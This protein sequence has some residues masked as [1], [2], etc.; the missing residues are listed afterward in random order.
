MDG[1]LEVD[2]HNEKI[3]QA[4]SKSSKLNKPTLISCK[5]IIG[6]DLPTNL[7]KLLHTVHL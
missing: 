2:G 3:S 7:E 4:I 5:T 6:F 1:I